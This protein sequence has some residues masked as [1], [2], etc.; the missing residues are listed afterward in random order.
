MAGTVLFLGL[1]LCLAALAAPSGG[2]SSRSEELERI[3]LEITRLEGRLGEVERL[4]GDQRQRLERLGLEVELQQERVVEAQTERRLVE[5]RLAELVVSI[6]DLEIRLETS[7]RTLQRGL[8]TLY[9]LGGGSTWRWVL[10]ARSGPQAL[11]GRRTLRYLSWLQSTRVETF[12]ADRDELEKRRAERLEQQ[13]RS[14]ELVESEKTRLGR[15]RVVR[16]EHAAALAALEREQQELAR[17]AAD[18]QARQERLTELFAYLASQQRDGPGETPIQRFK[19]VLDWPVTAR[20]LQRFGPRLDPRYGTRVPHNGITLDT[21]GGT[22]VRSIYPGVVVF[23]ED[24]EGFG[25]TVVIH[26]PTRVFTLFSGL[27]AAQVAKDDVVSSGQVVG[28]TARDLYFEIRRE[29]R[30][31]DPLEWLR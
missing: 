9:R 23:A 11:A 8:A 2:G 30:P 3:R 16:R 26:H 31:E 21:S 6:E 13:R 10:T 4:Q 1:V 29:D 25:I 28:R 19:G 14:R 17:R 5:E 22:Q 24:F 15:L 20:V 27:S 7:R 18:L 12:R